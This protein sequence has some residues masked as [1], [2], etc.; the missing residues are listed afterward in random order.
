MAQTVFS[1]VVIIDD[2]AALRRDGGIERGSEVAICERIAC[3]GNMPCYRIAEGSTRC[4]DLCGGPS[5]ALL[6][7]LCRAIALCCHLQRARI[8]W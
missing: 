8:A 3:T 1:V 7:T 6:F 2:R 4:S 5:R